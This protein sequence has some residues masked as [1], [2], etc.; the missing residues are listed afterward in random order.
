MAQRQ[1]EAKRSRNFL[2][3]ALLRDVEGKLEPEINVA[4]LRRD[5]V[6]MY[7]M[8]GDP[9]T[10]LRLPEPLEAGIQR[11]PAGWR[12]KAKRPAGAVRLEAGFRASRPTLPSWEGLRAGEENAVR[13]FEAANGAFAFAPLPSADRWE[14]QIDRPGWVRLVATGG[15]AI[16]VAVLKAE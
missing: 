7:A 8:L 1:L 13:A 10:R 4:K 16:Y 12:W 14:G 2:I 6:L 3:E 15:D 9:A 11:T 5:Q